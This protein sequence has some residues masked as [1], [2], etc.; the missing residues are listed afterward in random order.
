M[1]TIKLIAFCLV[2][3]S[4]RSTIIG[5]ENMPF[6]SLIRSPQDT[7]G[8][9][10]ETLIT[11]VLD[12]GV[13]GDGVVDDA[14]AIQSAIDATDDNIVLLPA[15]TYRIGSD[16]TVPVDVTLWLIGKLSVDA[17]VTVTINGKVEAGLHQIFSGGGTVTLGAGSCEHVVPQWWGAVG[18]DST[19]CHDAIE[20]AI[21]GATNIGK[22]Y[23]PPGTYRI[24]A[25]ID[26][27]PVGWSYSQTNAPIVEGAGRVYTVIKYI[28]T[29]DYAIKTYNGAM[30]ESDVY[31]RQTRLTIK[32]L[33][34][35]AL[36]LSSV[37]GCILSMGYHNRFEDLFLE[38]DA[39]YGTALKI[40]RRTYIA[41]EDSFT[42][43]TNR[44][45][46]SS[47]GGGATE[48]YAI[49]YTTEAGLTG[50]SRAFTVRLG[51]T[52]S[53]AGTITATVY[54]DSS[55]PDAIIGGASQTINCNDLSSAADGADQ[56]FIVNWAEAASFTSA[57]KFW[58]VLSTSG[59]TY[60]DGV[61]EVRLRVE[62]GAGAAN[63]FATYDDG[64]GTW[65]T[66]N[67]GGN[68]VVENALAMAVINYAN[69]VDIGPNT[70]NTYSAVGINVAEES[71]LFL[72]DSNVYSN[73]PF[74]SLGQP[75]VT[76]DHCNI[77][78]ND[79]NNYVVDFTN[80]VSSQFL[81]SGCY[82]E[83]GS[84]TYP[85]HLG[86]VSRGSFANCAISTY[87]DYEP[88]H[89]EFVYYGCPVFSIAGDHNMPPPDNYRYRVYTPDTPEGV[90]GFDFVNT[91]TTAVDADALTGTAWNMQANADAIYFLWY[92]PPGT[93]KITT[94]A[95]ATTPDGTDLLMQAQETNAAGPIVDT[96]TM[97][98][99][100]TDYA[101]YS[102]IIRWPANGNQTF[103]A[104][105]SYNSN[106]IFI[107]HITIEYI[108][109]LTPSTNDL[110]LFN[111]EEGDADG[112]RAV[113]VNFRGFK[114]G[115]EQSHL[116]TITASHDGAADDEK[117][118]LE[119]GVNDGSDAW[120]P[121]TR[122]TMDSAGNVEVSGRFHFS[123]VI[124]L[125]D[126][127]ATP[128]VAGGNVFKTA[129]T[130][131]TTITMFDDGMAGQKIT[132]IIGDAN[133]TMDFTGTNLK[134]NSGADWSPVSGDHMTCVFDGTN[135]YC[136]VSDNTP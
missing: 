115:G 61:T 101:P 87:V 54:S 110:I 109:P 30:S 56:E 59:Y 16:V 34:I 75:Y 76:L 7:Q 107:S 35:Q 41:T 15:G 111:A 31:V 102:H 19:D 3:F 116:A 71:Q 36:N 17:G 135:W 123:S 133:T 129:N 119:I 45:F 65:S 27:F 5:D 108:G 62:A 40:Q 105:V 84:T 23:L 92:F 11:T 26:N 58:I 22:V 47:G 112:D 42:N 69:A 124:T 38:A 39:T 103:I 2:I 63:T 96:N 86:K 52:G 127:D 43:D 48:K 125:S 114:S 21:T 24:T 83:G 28:G 73:N 60:T 122:L 9:T 44:D 29:S 80:C 104:W 50:K 134:G 18:D 126:G 130:G 25:P 106:D 95:K 98:A 118:K 131:A 81:A 8:F 1:S 117:G 68:Y 100:T 113:S 90:R 89:G 128:S 78:Q 6:G 10:E 4:I 99:L 46:T 37:G 66:S 64:A 12:Y 14:S 93:Y 132:V 121:T 136:D 32:H 88:G 77:D 91:F 13:T 70:D 72:T 74:F 53:P 94:Y 97:F 51:K 20:A 49:A 120:A 85:I 79:G 82:F 55:G 67:D 33:R 57:T